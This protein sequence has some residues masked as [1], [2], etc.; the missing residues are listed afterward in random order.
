M[1]H[2]VVHV[3]T[4]RLWRGQRVL[5]RVRTTCRVFLQRW[6]RLGVNHNHQLRGQQWHMRPVRC[7][8]Q[9]C[10]EWRA[11]GAMYV[12]RRV[13]FGRAQFK[14]VCWYQRHMRRVRC[15][16][17]LCGWQRPGGRVHLLRG[18]LLDGHRVCWVHRDHG[19]VRDV[20][21]RLRLCRRCCVARGLHVHRWSL[22]SSRRRELQ[23]DGRLLHGV[24]IGKRMRRRVRWPGHLRDRGVLLS[25]G[26]FRCDG[27]GLRSGQ[28]WHIRR[29][30]GV[31]FSDVRRRVH[32]LSGLVLWRL[33]D[34]LVGRAVHGGRR[35]ARA[36]SGVVCV[37]PVRAY[38]S[39]AV[40][41]S[42]RAQ[43]GYTCAG[44]AAQVR[45][46]RHHIA[47]AFLWSCRAARGIVAL[48]TAP[49]GIPAFVVLN[50]FLSRVPCEPA[51]DLLA[52]ACLLAACCGFDLCHKS[53]LSP[54]QGR[55][56][57]SCTFIFTTRACVCDDCFLCVAFCMFGFKCAVRQL[58]NLCVSLC[59]RVLACVEDA[60]ELISCVFMAVRFSC[61]GFD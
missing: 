30:V 29:G 47:L 6:L 19:D 34:R 7:G 45:G 22:F 31:R 36:A 13:C 21:S 52:P 26:V 56:R 24:S 35:R 40:L 41:S 55:H 12:L 18:I 49:H 11:G 38:C 58:M 17:Q 15:R 3:L 8:P 44:G 46:A 39:H 16:R 25:A 5:R 20:C 4:H 54:W 43:V 60:L 23:R 10:G 1:R 42:S 27:R 61:C 2:N 51:V 57:K 59:V 9:L 37:A 33:I 50:W 32:V 14:P 48:R 28:L 53:M